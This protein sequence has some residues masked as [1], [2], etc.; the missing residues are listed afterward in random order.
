M[1]RKY[2][3]SSAKNYAGQRGIF[4]GSKVY[5]VLNEGYVLIGT[6]RARPHAWLEDLR[7]R[8]GQRISMLVMLLIILT[9]T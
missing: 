7:Q 2:L 3:Y 5:R 8:G 1:S 4:I 6:S 9:K